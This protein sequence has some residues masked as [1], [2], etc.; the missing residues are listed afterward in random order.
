VNR[1][2]KGN[3]PCTEKSTAR[4]EED[5]SGKGEDKSRDVL[6][7]RRPRRGTV[8]RAR[9]DDRRSGSFIPSLQE[10]QRIRVSCRRQSRSRSDLREK[11]RAAELVWMQGKER[12]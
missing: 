1:G 2:R 5:L 10:V 12:N 11:V 9:M 8:I 3:T 7:E 4:V 6:W